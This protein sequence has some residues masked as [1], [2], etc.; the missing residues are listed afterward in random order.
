V[1]ERRLAEVSAS[2]EAAELLA[3]RIG[4]LPETAVRLLSAGA[5]LGKDFDLRCA[6]E[7]ASETADQALAALDDARRRHIVWLRETEDRCVF[8]HDKLREALLGRMTPGEVRVLHA[9]AAAWLEEHHPD[10]VFELAYHL[11]RAG[12]PERAVPFALAAGAQ[13][14]AQF[15]LELAQRYF[16]IAARGVEHA[17]DLPDAL[18]L[19]VAEGLG[20]VLMLRG[21]YGAAA[22]ELRRAAGL[23]RTRIERARIGG[24]LGELAFKQGD[25]ARASEE[26]QAAL[27]GLGRRVP[28]R[29]IGFLLRLASE[30]LVQALHT[31]VPRLCCGRRPLGSASE[32]RFLEIRLLSRLAYA[33]WFGRGM[34]PCAWAHLREMNLAERYPPTP[35][36]AQAYSEHA[37]AASMVPW[38]RRGLEYARRSFAIRAELGDV[39]GQGQSLHFAGV[40]LYAASRFEQSLDHC[41]RALR[42][43]EPTGDRWEANIAALHVAYC[44]YRLGRLEE[45][46]SLARRLHRSALEI[47]DHATAGHSL[48][49]W[50]KA[51]DGAVPLELVEAEQRH[52][53]EDVHTQV[54][55]LQARALVHLAAGDPGAAVEALENAREQIRRAGLRQE[56][57]AAAAPWLATA[58]RRA[59]EALPPDDPR[60]SALLER[61]RAATR[62]ALR[63]SRRFRNNLPHALRE[64]ALVEADRG[65]RFRA[66]TLLAE[67]M[68][69]AVAQGAG[70]ELRRTLEVR[71]A[72]GDRFGWPRAEADLPSPA[73][74]VSGA[75]P[76]P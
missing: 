75:D 40:V 5:V 25:V 66:R 14:R 64:A 52:L 46:A 55:L 72:L 8:V 24:R 30:V 23:A 39:W 26:L 45:A 63:L 59:R 65:R 49:V 13:A 11:D 6:L 44:H 9:R 22:L 73:L 2:A 71:T 58:L 10:R 18:R 42:L 29:R 61:Q 53:T 51:T 7:I 16:E 60:R 41:E 19:R 32:E 57:A 3:H 69:V 47:G 43:L 15:S 17:A 21:R 20:E 35:E 27:A 12:E 74:V 33:Y 36:L 68:A 31:L 37:P 50:A 62:R 28:R 67:S 70:D 34:V 76:P 56:Y 48:G 1:D 54:E 4:L 38:Y